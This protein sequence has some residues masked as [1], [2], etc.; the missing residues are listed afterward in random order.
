MYNIPWEASLGTSNWTR[1]DSCGTDTVYLSFNYN[2]D[3]ARTVTLTVKWEG[4]YANLSSLNAFIQRTLLKHND[5][6]LGT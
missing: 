5:L 4:E 2:H 1:I 3:D 6:T